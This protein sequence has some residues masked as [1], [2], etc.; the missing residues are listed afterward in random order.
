MKKKGT[1]E[2][3]PERKR[4]ETTRD[5]RLQVVT[6]RDHS[7]PQMSWTAIGREDWT[8]DCVKGSIAE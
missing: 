6:L 7:K 3:E 1:R 5:Q 8:V 4:K 2:D